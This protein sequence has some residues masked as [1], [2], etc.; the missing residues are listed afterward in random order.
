MLKKHSESSGET[1]PIDPK[2]NK[3]KGG[4]NSFLK[5]VYL[6]LEIEVH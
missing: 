4:R 5:I 6:H 1:K 3:A 2:S